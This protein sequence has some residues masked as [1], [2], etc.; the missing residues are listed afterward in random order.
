MPYFKWKLKFV[1]NIVLMIVEQQES[2]LF[3]KVE[4][5]DGMKNEQIY[6]SA[7]G[8]VRKRMTLLI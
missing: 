8:E 1:S 2:Y 5:A 3:L 4:Q 6:E 7:L